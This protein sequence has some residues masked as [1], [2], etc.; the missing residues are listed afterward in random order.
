MILRTECP[1]I[2]L[3]RIGHRQLVKESHI[4]RRGRFPQFTGYQLAQFRRGDTGPVLTDHERGHGLAGPGT[5]V[6]G[7][8]VAGTPMTAAAATPACPASTAST[9]PE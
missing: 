7:A 9:I 8:A 3:V 2:G 1:L 6:A 5:G 4:P